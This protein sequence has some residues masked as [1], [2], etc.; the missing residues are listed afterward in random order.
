M[1]AWISLLRKKPNQIMFR[2]GF[3]GLLFNPAYL[4]RS[5]LYNAV[6]IASKS[7]QGSIL[8]FGCGSK[9]YAHLFTNASSYIG[10][11]L[12]ISG[13]DHKASDVDIFFDGKNIPFP[14][15]HFDGV[16]SF[17]TLEHVFDINAVFSE[18][19]R[20]LKKD[21]QILL[22]I[23][24]AWPEHEQPYDFGRYTMF[25]IRAVLERHGFEIDEITKTGGFFMA[26]SQL[27]IEYFRSIAF[28]K[29]RAWRAIINVIFVFPITMLAM[30]CN[31][32]APKNDNFYFNLVIIARKS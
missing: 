25:G 29:A 4:I 31:L 16:V 20:V 18:F 23:P 24:F 21:G 10:I 30:I 2:P 6:S 9:P 14:N 27:W 7:M 15:E 12:E 26:M 32:F 11:D 8:D 1:R 19:H 3:F 17:E 22:T 13:H 5:A 28:P